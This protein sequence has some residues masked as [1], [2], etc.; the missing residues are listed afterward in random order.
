LQ[1]ASDEKGM[2]ALIYAFDRIRLAIGQAAANM[3]H[4]FYLRALLP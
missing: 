2:A 3:V 1:D 4:Y